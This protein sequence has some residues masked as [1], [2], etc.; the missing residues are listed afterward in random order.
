MLTSIIDILLGG[1]E[2]IPLQQVLGARILRSNKR[3]RLLADDDDSAPNIIVP[4]PEE[5][6]PSRDTDTKTEQIMERRDSDVVA[7]NISNGTPLS[8]ELD[9]D[10]RVE[11]KANELS[12]GDSNDGRVRKRL[13][14]GSSNSSV[15]SNFLSCHGFETIFGIMDRDDSLKDLVGVLYLCLDEKLLLLAEQGGEDVSALVNVI[16]YSQTP[17]STILG[18]LTS[19]ISGNAYVVFPLFTRLKNM[20]PRDTAPLSSDVKIALLAA[21]Y[22]LENPPNLSYEKCYQF[23]W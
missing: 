14:R 6:T 9:R 4:E 15:R 2:D 17:S 21:S 18:L 11:E 12:V 1:T 19:L 5:A 10:S 22:E 16:R 20:V 8:K 7:M 23:M 3:Q 13:S